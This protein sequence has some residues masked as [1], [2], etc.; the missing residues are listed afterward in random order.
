MSLSKILFAWE[1]GANL[2]HLTR[3]LPLARAC[4]DAG[5]DIVFAASDLRTAAALLHAER[6]T[7]LQAPLLRPIA[8]RPAP[9]VNY[10]D[11]LLHAGYD[12]GAALA[13]ALGGW[14]SLM[15]LGPVNTNREVHRPPARS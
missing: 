13:G 5:H 15:E 3:D 1:F 11:M 9:P 2:G 6:F 7:L 12:D 14:R 8:K 10:A 4:R